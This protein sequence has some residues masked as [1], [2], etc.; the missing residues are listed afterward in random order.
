MNI[1]MAEGGG[2]IEVQGTAEGRPF[3]RADLDRM[4]DL[5]AGGIARLIEL[6]RKVLEA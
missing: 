6:Q 5:A 4:L 1:I 3:A 2:L